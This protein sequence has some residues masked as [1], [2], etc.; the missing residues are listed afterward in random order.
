DVAG[1]GMCLVS[2]YQSSSVAAIVIPPTSQPRPG[3]R[4]RRAR[5]TSR[6]CGAVTSNCAKIHLRYP[7]DTNCSFCMGCNLLVNT[8]L[9]RWRA[10][11]L[12]IANRRQQMIRLKEPLRQAGLDAEE[13][14]YV[15]AAGARGRLARR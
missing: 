6:S 12:L 9:R 14:R 11:R 13:I 10:R 2:T 7:R 4:D 15:L 5:P 3:C 8:P 1:T